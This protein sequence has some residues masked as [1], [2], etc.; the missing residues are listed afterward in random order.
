MQVLCGYHGYPN[1]NVICCIVKEA[2]V[3]MVEGTYS[4]YH[5]M[6]DG[7]DDKV[8]IIITEQ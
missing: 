1:V 3:A 5:Y 6:Q 7:I 8:I 4:Y 2:V